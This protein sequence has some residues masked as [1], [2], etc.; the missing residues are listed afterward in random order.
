M[1][2]HPVANLFPMMAQD[3]FQKLKDDIAK[4]GLLEPVTIFKGRL[5]DGRNRYRACCELGITPQYREWTPVGSLESFVISR[6][7]HR[8]HLSESQRAMIGARLKSLF[9]KEAQKRKSLSG[10]RY[11]GRGKK[12]WVPEDL[13]ESKKGDSRDAAAREVN[14][15]GRTI[16][17]AKIVLKTGEPR[18]VQKVVKGEISVHL[19][20]QIAQLPYSDQIKLLDDPNASI[21]KRLARNLSRRQMEARVQENRRNELSARRVLPP[22]R[23]DRFKLFVRNLKNDV[24]EIPSNSIDLIICDPPYKHTFIECYS[25]LGAFAKRTLKYGGS[26]VVLCGHHHLFEE[27]KILNKHLN[28]YWLLSY[29][30]PGGKTSIGKQ[31]RVFIKWKP[32]L[33]YVKGIY[34]GDFV[35]DVCVLKDHH[36]DKNL[37]IWQQPEIGMRSIIEKFVKPGDTVCDPFCGAGTTGI[38]ALQKECLFIGIDID[39]GCIETTRF[40]LLR[41]ID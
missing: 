23:K 22:A 21:F 6:N 41:R 3:E 8:R 20:S 39:A 35:S 7:L 2:F 32:V 19:A 12:V 34:K 29:G 36:P 18:L 37:H 24:P 5:I 26:L 38:I 17:K 27:M 25:Y 30:L 15:S 40:R 31:R 11:G 33:W 4:N 28:Y 16:D 14:V 9:E 1:E 13:P 10:R